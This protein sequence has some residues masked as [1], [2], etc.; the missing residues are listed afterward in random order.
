MTKNMRSA[1]CWTNHSLFV[2][3]LRI[4]PARRPQSKKAPK[5]LDVLKLNQ[6]STR[7]AF[8]NDRNNHLLLGETN[9]SSEEYEDW[10]DFQ[11]VGHS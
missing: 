9:P 3:N 7:H 4:Q 11:N 8:I 5:R 10:T 2:S 6:N 1:D